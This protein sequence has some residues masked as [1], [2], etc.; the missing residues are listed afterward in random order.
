MVCLTNV[1][2][3]LQRHTPTIVAGPGVS[4][5]LIQEMEILVCSK[6]INLLPWKGSSLLGSAV[7]TLVSF[8]NLTACRA[9]E[10]ARRRSAS[11]QCTVSGTIE[12]RKQL[13]HSSSIFPLK[14][15]VSLLCGRWL[16]CC[17]FTLKRRSLSTNN[18]EGHVPSWPGPD[19]R[20]K[21]SSRRRTDN[22]EQAWRRIIII[23]CSL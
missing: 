3:M 21:L 10:R 14:Y 4:P 22:C 20:F 2:Q 6:T 16:L 9:T 17:S 19:Q 23:G 15:A 18:P 8:Y 5:R 1:W 11:E 7:I 12:L 13:L